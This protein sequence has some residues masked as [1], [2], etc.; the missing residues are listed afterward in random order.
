MV[1]NGIIIN[2][3]LAF[4]YSTVQVE[5]STVID[6]VKNPISGEIKAK[7]IRE[8]ILDDAEIIAA[9]TRY[10]LN[11]GIGRRGSVEQL[12]STHTIA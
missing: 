3:D 6:S 5:A 10:E 4:E 11:E 7:S 1:K 8:L 12:T 2:T 9:D